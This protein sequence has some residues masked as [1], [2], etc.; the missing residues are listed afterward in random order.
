MTA[1]VQRQYASVIGGTRQATARPMTMLP[2][3]NRLANTSSVQADDQTRRAISTIADIAGAGMSVVPGMGVVRRVKVV[4]SSRRRLLLWAL[5]RSPARS[6]A[7]W[8][9]Q[10]VIRA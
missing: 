10:C 8:N 6:P 5:R 3:Q 9:W 2:A 1:P 7:V 4:S